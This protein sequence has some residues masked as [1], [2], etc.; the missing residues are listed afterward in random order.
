MR[1]ETDVE[2]PHC[3]YLDSINDRNVD[4]KTLG[5]APS[6]LLLRRESQVNSLNPPLRTF[7]STYKTPRSVAD[8]TTTNDSYA[9]HR[10]RVAECSSKS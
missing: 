7:D 2:N 1:H 4:V 3:C 9:N 6:L 8:V 5:W 10:D